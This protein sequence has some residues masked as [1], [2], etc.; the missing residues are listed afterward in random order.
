MDRRK[1]DM[2]EKH[3]KEY[4]PLTFEE[5]EDYQFVIRVCNHL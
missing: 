2:V 3:F 1:K 4:K 5:C